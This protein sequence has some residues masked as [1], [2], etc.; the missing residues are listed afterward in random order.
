VKPKKIKRHAS[1]SGVV[2]NIALYKINISN[3]C[4]KSKG[5]ARHKKMKNL[6]LDIEETKMQKL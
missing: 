6:T 5:S 1:P 3:G 4:K 2:P